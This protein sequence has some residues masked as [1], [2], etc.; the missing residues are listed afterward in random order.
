MLAGDAVPSDD[1]GGI[2]SGGNEGDVDDIESSLEQMLSEITSATAADEGHGPQHRRANPDAPLNRTTA[3]VLGGLAFSEYER[4]VD[5]GATPL[6]A[7]T[8]PDGTLPDNLPAHDNY[9][10]PGQ[11]DG[12]DVL[13]GRPVPDTPNPPKRRPGRTPAL[14]RQEVESIRADTRPIKDIA[15]YWG[16]SENTIRRVQGRGVHASNPYVPVEDYEREVTRAAP[17]PARPRTTGA[18]HIGRPFKSRG[19]LTEDERKAIMLSQEPIRDIAER[20]KVSTGTVSRLRAL[21]RNTMPLL[22]DG[23]PMTLE[24]AVLADV[25]DDAT[26]ARRFGVTVTTVRYIRKLGEQMLEDI[27]AHTTKPLPREVTDEDNTDED[28]D[29]KAE[30]AE[31]VEA[32]RRVSALFGGDPNTSTDTDTGGFE[33]EGDFEDFQEDDL[34]DF[35]GS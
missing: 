29:D 10:V 8:L 35:E 31:I 30:K 18:A 15:A 17:A 34:G 27:K 16:V 3:D 20:Y 12:R 11:I 6:A 22:A 32:Q 21:G 5:I 9:M 1:A 13:V 23:T 2:T 4:L 25:R 28:T 19:P 14:Y 33:D 26:V 24:Q 7:I